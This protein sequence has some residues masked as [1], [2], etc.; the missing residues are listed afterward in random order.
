M[1][2][3]STRVIRERDRGRRPLQEFGEDTGRGSASARN[4]EQT[5]R[6]VDPE[7]DLDLLAIERKVQSRSDPNFEHPPIGSGD[8]FAAIVLELVLP[9][10]Q[11]EDRWQNPAVIKIHDGLSAI[12]AKF[13]YDYAP[14]CFHSASRRGI[15]T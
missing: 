11:I 8:H 1:T 13:T 3:V 14:F 6:R 4:R 2:T 7:Y 15:E 9:H 5:G 12:S 10:D